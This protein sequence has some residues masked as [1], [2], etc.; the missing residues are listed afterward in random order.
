MATTQWPRR[1]LMNIPFTIDQFLGVFE[2]YNQAIWPMQVLAYILGVAAVG[3]AWKKTRYSDRVIGGILAVFWLWIG[4]V[5]HLL[6]FSSINPAAFGF[7]ALFVIQGILFS[8]VGVAQAKLSFHARTD[9]F[10]IVGGLFILYAMI[11]YPILGSFLGHSYPQSPV[12]G[13]APCPATIFT[14]GMLLWTDH[15]VPKYVLA[16]PLIWSVIGF[17]AA[18][19]LGIR[20]D[21]GLLIAGVLGTALLFWRDRARADSPTMPSSML[22]R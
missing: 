17:G 1:C 21:L 22:W 9:I 20:E 5:Y 16:I 19:S 12:F 15:K 14:F 13:V 3:L 10:S 2:R 6:F 11:I 8:V 4:V 7:G 18:L